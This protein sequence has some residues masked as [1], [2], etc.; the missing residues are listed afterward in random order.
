MSSF[1]QYLFELDR[2]TRVYVRLIIE[3]FVIISTYYLWLMV[4]DVRVWEQLSWV[5]HVVNACIWMF[6]YKAFGL[7]KDHLRYSSLASYQ[8]IFRI[9]LFGVLTLALEDFIFTR[10]FDIIPLL[11]FFLLSLNSLVGLR[12]I[13]RQLI[14]RKVAK[15]RENILVYG[16]SEAAIDLVNA[17]AYGKKYNVVAFISDKPQS[18]DSLAGLPVIALNHVE[19]YAR[20]HACKLVVLT[21]DKLSRVNQAQLLLQLDKLGFSVSYAPTIDRAFDYEVQLKAVK[22]EDVLGRVSNVDFDIS[23]EAELD[24]KVVLVTGAGGSIG[25]EICRQILR[26]TPEKLVVLELNEFA[27]Y[28]LEQ[29]IS[30]LLAKVKNSTRIDYHL[31]SV[32]DEAI[33]SG[34]FREQKIDIV[35]HAAAYKHVPIVEDNIIAGITN[36]VLGTKC[37][38][39]FAHRFGV[40][41]FVLVST[42]K[43]VRPTNVMGASKRLAELVIQDFSHSSETIFTMV[44]FG[45]VLGSS[46]SVIPK[47]KSQIN[48]GGPITV[49]HKEVTRYF[50]SI[51][52]AAHLV[53]TA[54]TFASGGDVFLLDMDE[55]V[56]ILE[57]AKSMVRQHGLQPVLASKTTGH[58]K[59]HNEILIEFTGLRSGEKLYEE[60]LV[61]GVAEETP[62]PKIFKSFDGVIEKMDIATELRILEKNIRDADPQAAINQLLRLPLLYQP[63]I[64]QAQKTIIDEKLEQSKTAPSETLVAE[65]SSSNADTQYERLSLIKRIVNSKLGLAVLHRYFLMTRGMTLG[66]RVLV[67]NHKGEIL[68]VKHTYVPGWHL[69]GGGVDH[70][71]DVDAAIV[72][73]VYE[74]CGIKEL[75][76]LR[77]I[78][79]LFNSKISKRDHIVLYTAN[80]CET[81]TINNNFEIE[82]A[83]FFQ[84]SDLPSDVD[85]IC[86]TALNEISSSGIG[87]TI[88]E[89]NNINLE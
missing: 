68:L 33:L 46:G 60:L 75:K 48:S 51:P 55:P 79:I 71:E 88:V 12:I 8:P 81:P 77:L 87:K 36:N 17:M 2:P 78:K 47:F 34:I 41:K 52:E 69:P 67:Q 49:T 65:N 86:T 22:P 70:S 24:K 14:R 3:S 1:L 4:S 37:I 23:V 20:I 15:T 56:K 89:K 58:K 28:K 83:K 62:N 35:Y 64:T 9:T 73:E 18:M 80:V 82:M 85:P 72:R 38:A 26:Y 31:G 19:R 43:A 74:E 59:R 5:I 32:C 27:L 10:S 50:M 44:R 40:E 6:S 61:D 13:A 30:P 57:L 66:V 21:S 16:T 39:D 29:E 11:I 42:D 25:S 45:N 53:L 84:L 7:H 63:N 76:D 54:G